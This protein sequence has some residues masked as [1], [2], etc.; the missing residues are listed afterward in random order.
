M[1][2][3]N[4]ETMTCASCGEAVLSTEKFCKNCGKP[5]GQKNEKIVVEDSP[6]K[7]VLLTFEALDDQSMKN[8]YGQ[9]LIRK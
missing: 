5:L 2:E 1:E 9:V 7:K 6:N 8:A 3:R 4:L